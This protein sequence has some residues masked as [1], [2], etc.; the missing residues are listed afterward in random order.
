MYVVD[1]ERAR[2]VRERAPKLAASSTDEQVKKAAT[3][4][5]ECIEPDPTSKVLFVFAAALLVFLTLWWVSHDGPEGESLP[6]AVG[7]SP[8]TTP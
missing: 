8:T 2:T 3:T 4:L 1:P 5:R 6:K 7:G